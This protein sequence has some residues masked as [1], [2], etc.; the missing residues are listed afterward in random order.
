MTP[1]PKEKTPIDVLLEL[2]ADRELALDGRLK[3]TEARLTEVKVS[4]EMEIENTSKT[5]RR[6]L[7]AESKLRAAESLIA[8]RITFVCPYAECIWPR[9]REQEWQNRPACGSAVEAAQREAVK[10]LIVTPAQPG[11]GPEAPKC[12]K[13]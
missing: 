8:Q 11:E 4:L 3:F 9:C 2:A 12:I 6:A 5:M 10:D 13:S 1:T 7:K